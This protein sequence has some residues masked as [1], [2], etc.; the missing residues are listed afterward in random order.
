MLMLKALHERKFANAK[1][2]D[3]MIQILGAQRFNDAIP[4]GL[5][6][7]VTVAHKTGSI[8]KHNHD[9]ALIFPVVRKPYILVVLTRGIAEEKKSD[10]LIANISRVVYA[11][12]TP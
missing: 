2:C 12:L 7:D 6:R 3:K 11:A 1:T 10:K 9:A 4:A 8:T 5:P